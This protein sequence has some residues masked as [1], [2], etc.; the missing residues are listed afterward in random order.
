[1][2]K[3]MMLLLVMLAEQTG[4]QLSKERMHFMAQ[5]LLPLGPSVLQ[6][7]ER[8]LDSAKRFPTV[9]DIKEAMGIKQLS[10]EQEG[11]DIAATLWSAVCKFCSQVNDKKMPQIEAYVGPIGW[12]IVERLGGWNRF[13]DAAS[14][15]D[16]GI[17]MAQWRELAAVFA[18]RQQ[19]DQAIAR[20]PGGAGNPILSLV[21]GMTNIVDV[22]RK[23]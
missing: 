16:Q 11:R 13:V 18:I 6:A 2:E 14:E 19:N 17:V 7:M 15:S 12:A 22:G 3:Q 21:S 10:P 8:L 1:M 9:Q 23:R 5:R 4:E 20:L